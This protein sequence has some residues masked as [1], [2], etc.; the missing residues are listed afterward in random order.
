MSIRSR[1]LL[2][3]IGLVVFASGILYIITSLLLYSFGG[4]SWQGEGFPMLADM[5]NPTY[6]DLR[7]VTANSACGVNLDDLYHRRVIGCDAFGRPGIG[8]PPMSI[9]LFRLFHFDAG[10]TNLLAL[11]CGL[12]FI[13]V[14]GYFFS[15]INQNR[16]ATLL[17]AGL[18]LWSYPVQIGL[19]KLN[20]DVIIYILI[21]LD[22]YLLSLSSAT[23]RTATSLAI[24]VS[25]V[26]MKIYPL[27]GYLGLLFLAKPIA[28]PSLGW[29]RLNKLDA[30][31]ILTGCTIA[32]ISATPILLGNDALPAGSVSAGQGGLGS[33]GLKALGFLNQP[34]LN[35]YGKELGRWMIRSLFAMKILSIITGFIVT[36]NLRIAEDI[37][38]MIK[39]LP[40]PKTSRFITYALV[41]MTCM[42]LGC[43]ATTISYDYRLIFLIPMIAVLPQ[44]YSSNSNKQRPKMIWAIAVATMALIPGISTITYWAFKIW[45]ENLIMGHEVI[46]EFILFPIVAGS[47]AALMIQFIEWNSFPR[48][49]QPAPAPTRPDPHR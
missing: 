36:S 30:A 10:W 25:T 40:N 12:T 39:S 22:C 19:E 38:L 42:W 2:W 24:V 9:W 20:I 3:W 5:R 33:H 45:Q 13:T 16:G 27:F 31:I 28:K 11:A 6:A 23:W 29:L 46:V 7:W 4:Y 48:H 8:Y 44:V 37:K 34:L 35:L 32:M 49:L 1:R 26:G 21:I 43:Y 15:K 47:A 17:T 14:S 18:I 41:S